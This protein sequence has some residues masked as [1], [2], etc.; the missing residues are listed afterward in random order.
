[1]VSLATQS[2][3]GQSPDFIQTYL[4]Q[5]RH[6]QPNPD[7]QTDLY[8]YMAHSLAGIFPIQPTGIIGV[9]RNQQCIALKVVLPK[10]EAGLAN[11][12]FSQEIATRLYERVTGQSLSYWK[13]VE[14]E[15]KGDGLT[16]YVYC[17]GN[18]T[19]ITWDQVNNTQML[20]SDVSIYIDS[21]CDQPDSAPLREPI[22]GTPP[23]STE[24]AQ[25]AQTSQTTASPAPG[26]A[27]LTGAN[28]SDTTTAETGVKPAQPITFNDIEGHLYADEILKAAN[29]Y[30]F[31]SGY[32]DGSFK[33]DQSLTREQGIVM[34]VNALKGIIQDPKDI[35]VPDEV[36]EP[37]F[38]D[39][40]AN[41][42]SA[43]QFFFAKQAR[44]LS[45][46]DRN[47]CN[48]D[49]KLT[50]AELI[51]VVR[52]GLQY[53]VEVNYDLPTAKLQDAIKPVA[54]FVTFT[55]LN[56]HWA[57]SI[58]QEMST[59]GIASALNETGSKYAPDTAASRGYAAATLVRME[60]VQLKNPLIGTRPGV[61]QSFPD[62]GDDIYKD[63]ILKAANQY[64]IITGYEDGRFCPTDPVSREQAVSI[65]VNAMGQLAK[66]PSVVA[67]PD[68]LSDPP[69]FQDVQ[70][71]EAARKIQFAKAAGIISGDE[72]GKFNPLNPL[73]RAALMSMINNALVYLIQQATGKTMAVTEVIKPVDSPASF[74][75]IPDGY[76]AAS[77]V[78]DMATV[79]IATPLNETGTAFVPDTNALRDFTAAAM[80]RM[81][82]ADYTPSAGTK[83]ALPGT[84][85][86]F[87]DI[88]NNPYETEILRAAN[89]YKIVSGYDDSSFKPASPVNREQAVA[90]IVDALKY[91]VANPDAIV[92]PDHLTQPPF[93]DVD[94]NRWS[95]PKLYFA[96]QVGLIS[97]DDL[98]RFNPEAQLSRA[99]LMAILNKALDYAV[100]ADFNQQQLA[101]SDITKTDGVTPHQFTDVPSTHWAS[102]MIDQMNLIGLTEPISPDRPNRFEPDTPAHR[103]FTV[104]TAVHMI[105]TPYTQTVEGGEISFYDISTSPYAPEILKAV[106]T[107]QII[108]GN[109]D[110][111]FRPAESISREQVVS[112][113]VESMQK[114]ADDP[115]LMD[116]PASV[117]KT[118]FEDVPTDSI[119]AAKIEFV[120]GAGIISG[121]DTGLFHPKNDM[122]RVQLMAVIRNTLQYIVTLN[123]GTGVTLEQA[124]QAVGTPPTFTDISGHWGQE[125][126]EAMATYG[127]ADPYTQGSHEFQPDKPSRRDFA[128]ASMVAMIEA[129]LQPGTKPASDDVPDTQD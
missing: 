23:A 36:T 102:T 2:L 129:V 52:N 125:V 34:L 127:I 96:R 70:T 16:H 87:N 122:T 104:A 68:T 80:V 30:R 32:D 120:V 35:V 12:M 44:I 74:T 89:Q 21:R 92:I 60:E 25:I 47:R 100:W 4:G 114:M 71:G 42:K 88:A 10:T 113:L 69:P 94:I 91:K 103:D 39:V 43:P 84:T 13:Q 14:A 18:Q 107:Y 111:S 66:D 46:D 6:Y 26:T 75:D 17:M 110:G 3:L 33:P 83:P 54:E 109:E 123:Q 62:I 5:P 79:G 49:A 40:P 106:N 37:P 28:R 99:Q 38:V 81:L 72:A 78:N 51:T 1:M 115:A 8:V 9:F 116:I 85:V 11:F 77:V 128:A 64:H 27:I 31:I 82:E 41:H 93:S 112:M 55:D 29:T 95:A 76:W 20:A 108:S 121:D 58:I 119:F 124:L 57:T 126:I 73:S 101:L 105:E 19:A 63:D 56:G 53:A 118:H 65:L 90:M 67:I 45:G 98:G 59:Y 7:N 22:V 24:T 97:G 48:P 50:R 86:S 117:T 15:P 61:P